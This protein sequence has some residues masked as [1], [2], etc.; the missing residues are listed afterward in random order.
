MGIDDLLVLQG[1]CK[2]DPESYYDDFL[3]RLR[4]YKS[5]LVRH[6]ARLVS[7]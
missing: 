1:K 6:A 4:H 2:T 7:G 5:L 3:M